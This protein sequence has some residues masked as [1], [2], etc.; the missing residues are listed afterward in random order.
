MFHGPFATAVLTTVLTA[1]VILLI[2]VEPGVSAS[3]H[4]KRAHLWS[5][6]RNQPDMTSFSSYYA[7]YPT[8][9]NHHFR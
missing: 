6:V 3:L 9:T 4:H 8:G 2:A 7:R 1:G 5:S